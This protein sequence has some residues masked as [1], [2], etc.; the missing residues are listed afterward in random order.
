MST[1]EYD[2]DGYV[3]EEC[4]N[5]SVADAAGMVSGMRDHIYM[6]HTQT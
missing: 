1:D 6:R 3:D 2:D 5:E 4:D